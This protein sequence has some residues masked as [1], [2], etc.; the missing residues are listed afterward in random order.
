MR[1]IYI[2]REETKRDHDSEVIN[3]ARLARE[4]GREEGIEIGE[5]RGISIGA[6]KK[7]RETAL[8][9]KAK[10]LDNKFIAECL[11]ISE[12]DVENILGV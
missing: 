10:G 7:T 9:M 3:T 1:E 6:K 4:E 5:K 2:A 11:N 12:E 8:N